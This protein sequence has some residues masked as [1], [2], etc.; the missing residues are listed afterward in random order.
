MVA[1]KVNT[2]DFKES[3]CQGWAVH[4][5]PANTVNSKIKAPENNLLGLRKK[6]ESLE[7]DSIGP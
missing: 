6:I 3:V 4:L 2:S 1:L 7:V 5:A